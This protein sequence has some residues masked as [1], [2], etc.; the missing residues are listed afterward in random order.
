MTNQ[1]RP[2]HR[3]I[4]SIGG[5]LPHVLDQPDTTYVLDEDIV[6]DD[7]AIKI[8]AGGVTLDF[9][10]HAITY[11]DCPSGLPNADFE[12]GYGSNEDDLPA[13]WDLTGAPAAKR[14]STYDC[15]MVNR[16]YLKLENPQND[17]EIVSPWIDLPPNRKATARFVRKERA[18]EYLIY[19][20]LEVEH[21]GEGVVASFTDAVR[22]SLGFTTFAVPGKYRLKLT[23]LYND[24][25]HA[26]TWQRESDYSV[27]DVV[28]PTI[29]NGCLYKVIADAGVSGSA[30]PEW[31]R[32]ASAK[33]T[34]GDLTWLSYKYSPADLHVDLV[35]LRLTG[36]YGIEILPNWDGDSPGVVIENGK[37]VQGRGG[38]VHSHAI[39]CHH[40][41]VTVRDMQ[42]ENWGVEAAAMRFQYSDGL[43]IHDNVINNNSPYTYNRHQLSAPIML[44]KCSHSR[45]AG[46]T[47]NSA[48][49]WGTIYI[50]AGNNNIVSGNTLKTKSVIT[51]HH[52]IVFYDV[53]DSLIHG[54]VIEGDPGQGIMLSMGCSGNN[55]FEN[56]ITIK[57]VAPNW[58]I[59][60]GISLH[61]IRSNDYHNPARPNENNRVHDNVLRVFGKQSEFY[62][63]AG[64]LVNGLSVINIG[65]G[66]LYENNDIQA[67]AVDPEVA[68][69]G[70][71]PGSTTEPVVYRGNRVESDV[72]N[73]GF[74][75]Y[76]M[77]SFNSQFVSNTFV[78]GSNA[79]EDYATLHA[80]P[81]STRWLENTYFVD[82]TLEN[83]ASLE[84]LATPWYLP[85]SYFVEWHLTVMVEDTAG[86]PVPEADV[87]IRDKNDVIVFSGSTDQD[88]KIDGIQLREYEHYG[89]GRRDTASLYRYSTPHTV[90]ASADGF[91]PFT[92]PVTMDATAAMT[93]TLTGGFEIAPHYSPEED[94]IT[95]F[96]KDEQSSGTEIN[97]RL[98]LY[99][100]TASNKTIGCKISGIRKLLEEQPPPG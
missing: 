82:S 49:G 64:H 26:A 80:H 91:D 75:G 45:I 24:W 61:A 90:T 3:C 71:M 39:D 83:G 23:Y 89:E 36:D 27:G 18:W 29:P 43:D 78:K 28:I 47:V 65:E 16:W 99:R 77:R 21:D 87:E 92:M 25:S 59:G 67:I 2:E 12:I 11:D 81:R 51:N 33:I 41:L 46:N 37:I 19:Y 7:T 54:N 74:G 6:A 85:Y 84:E 35:D 1:K 68:V 60:R 14:T 38:G 62:E 76:P 94:S 8:A 48:A 93:F 44:V 98:T 66:N 15:P 70:I 55:V 50:G 40:N 97:E 4:L 57:S 72:Y 96:W 10:G 88:G 32:Y 9:N 20:K 86:D 5:D 13:S 17:Q 56:T 73:V 31:K 63:P 30:E 42:I 22:Y 95:I 79:T 52:A 58:D 53:D 69:C 34:D 100:S